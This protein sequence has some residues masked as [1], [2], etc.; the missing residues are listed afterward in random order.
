MQDNPTF[1][2]GVLNPK[3][4]PDGDLTTY[5]TESQLKKLEEKINNENTPKLPLFINHITKNS[6]GEPAEPS[7]L[8]EYAY[9]NPNNKKLYIAAS[10]NDNENGRLA[11]QLVFDEKTP[12][13]EFSLGYNVYMK[14]DESGIPIPVDNEGHEVSICYVGA[15]EGTKIQIAADKETILNNKT[16]IKINDNNKIS[17]SASKQSHS[18]INKPKTRDVFSWVYNIK[19]NNANSNNFKRNN[20]FNYS[21]IPQDRVFSDLYKRSKNMSA[22]TNNVNYSLD[23]N[24]KEFVRP[25]PIQLT[26]AKTTREVLME[27]MRSLEAN[28]TMTIIPATASATS[29]IDNKPLDVTNLLQFAHDNKGNANSD[30]SASILANIDK[31]DLST[32]TNEEL[33]QIHEALIKEIKNTSAL[34]PNDADNLQIEENIKKLQQSLTPADENFDLRLTDVQVPNEA[35]DEN[36][37]DEEWMKKIPDSLPEDV[38]AGIIRD[39][40]ENRQLKQR[41]NEEKRKLIRESQIRLQEKLAKILPYYIKAEREKSGKNFTESD[42]EALRNLFG[43]LPYMPEPMHAG[44]RNFIE[45]QASFVTSAKENGKIAADSLEKLYKNVKENKEKSDALIQKMETLKRTLEDVKKENEMLKSQLPYGTENDR[46]QRVSASA[47]ASSDYEVNKRQRNG[48]QNHTN[49]MVQNGVT[50]TTSRIQVPDVSK[51][52]REGRIAWEASRNCNYGVDPAFHAY[53]AQLYD[54]GHKKA[55]HAMPSMNG[56]IKDDPYLGKLYMASR[57]AQLRGKMMRD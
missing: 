9:I 52:S 19:N 46:L 31:V 26:G 50:T 7:G 23:P 10:L 5:F 45:A 22:S 33:L 49:I 51:M 14:E 16:P 27:S 12:M 37:N 20:S 4:E 1:L 40:L 21:N 42:A 15:R 56:P 57:E 8:V 54:T 36:V 29:Q 43:R 13:R 18:F 34:L 41:E 30:T 44:I 24:Y 53:V 35:M 6:S 28:N 39:R 55:T 2:I 11:K 32:K 17:V 25:K 38:K 48:L 47:S 3:G